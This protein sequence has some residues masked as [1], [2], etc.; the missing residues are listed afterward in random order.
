MKGLP[1][2]WRQIGLVAGGDAG[3]TAPARRSVMQGVVLGLIAAFGAL[4]YLHVL[5]LFPAGRLWK[6]DTEAL[7]FLAPARP[8]ILICVLSILATPAFEEFIFRGLLLHGLLTGARPVLW[9]FTP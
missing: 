3:R 9:V 4:I 8:P 2:L 6:Q 5:G 1:D 7:S